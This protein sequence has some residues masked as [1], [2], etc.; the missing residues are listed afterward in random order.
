MKKVLLIVDNP[1]REM[2]G[3]VAILKRL[4]K[5]K[6]FTYIA[7][8]IS[9][10][11]WC[12][13][14][15]PDIVVLPRSTGNPYKPFIEKNY[16]HRKIII[17]PSEH[18][19]GIEKKML[20]FNFGNNFLN[21]GKIDS[22]IDLVSLILVGGENQKKW[23]LNSMPK[24]SNKVKVV[25]TLNSDH[26]LKPKKI[27]KLKKIKVGICTTF[28][29][30][31][32]STKFKSPHKLLYDHLSPDYKSNQW[33]LKVLDVE[34]H[35]LTVLF[36]AIDKLSKAG[37]DIDIRPHP[38]ENF[39]GWKYWFK[40]LKDKK[41]ISLNRDTDITSWIDSNNICITTFSSTSLDCI[42]R[43]IPA[44][45]LEKLVADQV[46]RMPKFKQLLTGEYSWNPS[47]FEEMI[48]L[49]E[50]EKNGNLDLS[51]NF[52]SAENFM[53]DNFYWPRDIS[54]ATICANEILNL[55]SKQT[56]KKKRSLMSMTKIPLILLKI[57]LRDIRD[58]F[59]GPRKS[60]LLF[61]F[62]LRMWRSSF[63]FNSDLN[64]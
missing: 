32:L 10:N 50:K 47:S 11:E 25:G 60:N 62:S 58:F 9:L 41:N 20:T 24:L 38:H 7:S 56:T 1:H 29:S 6:I 18:G 33:R 45:S 46:E 16:N 13:I 8:K 15:E 36:E 30:L 21:D 49:I 39:D 40:F 48:K 57:V 27:K 3:M 22:A 17:I 42:A 63:K 23:I 51:P 34:Q 4:R 54:S 44:I 61:I 14:L 35:Y 26:W 64:L 5:E 37:Y 19:S 28:K 31:F 2:R 53:R 43:G 12:K 59:F 52:I 55:I